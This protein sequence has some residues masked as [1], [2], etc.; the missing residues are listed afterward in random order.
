M[1]GGFAQ[2]SGR[3]RV[4]IDSRLHSPFSIHTVSKQFLDGENNHVGNDLDC[5]AGFDAAG[6]GSTVAAQSQ[7]GLL[8]ERWAGADPVDS[9]HSGT[10]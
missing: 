8:P 6:V 7:L 2:Q 10:A 9:G 5:V 3:T 1:D 4:S